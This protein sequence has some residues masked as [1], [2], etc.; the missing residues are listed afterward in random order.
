LKQ[1]KI[2]LL[3]GEVAAALEADPVALTLGDGQRSGNRRAKIICT[4]GPASNSESALRTCCGLGW[5][6]RG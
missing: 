2:D 6:S 3:S 1:G 4:V 5:M